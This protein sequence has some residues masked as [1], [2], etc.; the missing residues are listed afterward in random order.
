[1]SITLKSVCISDPVEM[2][3]GELL[4]RHDI[5]VAI[6]YKMSKQE[7]IKEL[8]YIINIVYKEI[9]ISLNEMRYETE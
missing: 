6:K 1:M 8:Q 4:A 5:P 3:C 9:L 2:R 7:L